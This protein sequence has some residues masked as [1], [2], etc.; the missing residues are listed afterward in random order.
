[1]EEDENMLGKKAPNDEK[2]VNLGQMDSATCSEVN[3]VLNENRQCMVNAV[4]HPD[5][6]DTLIIPKMRYH[7]PGDGTAPQD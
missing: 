7:K 3:G 5:D 4:R 2:V 1:L 6:P